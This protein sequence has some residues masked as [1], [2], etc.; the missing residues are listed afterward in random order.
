M[1]PQG[2]ITINGKRVKTADIK[3]DNGV[4]HMVTDVIYPFTP[5]STIADLVSTDE[6]YPWPLIAPLTP[7]LPRFST[8]LAAVT[9]AGLAD[10]LASPGPFT[11]FAPT[12]AAFDKVSSEQPVVGPDWWGLRFPRPLSRRCWPTRKP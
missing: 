8:L 10:T 4:I 1:T 12:N 6:R 9:A 7:T 11:V 3:A 5:E 2:F